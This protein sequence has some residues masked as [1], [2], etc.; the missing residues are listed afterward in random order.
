MVSIFGGL[1]FGPGKVGV[2][3]SNYRIF[4]SIGI[5][6]CELL[7]PEEAQKRC[8]IMSVDGVLGAM[9]ADREGY[10]DTTGTVQAYATCS[11]KQGAE[12][13][14]E[15]KVD[16]LEQVTDGWIVKTAEVEHVVNAA[17]WAKQVGRLSG[18]DVKMVL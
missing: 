8:P 16:S 12:Y 14:E 2:V 6:D 9:W 7:T 1:Y 17:F 11:R 4:Q 3:Q 15:V 10:I 13:Y 18:I 5:S